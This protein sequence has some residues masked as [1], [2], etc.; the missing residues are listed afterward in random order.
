M[1]WL[2]G[3]RVGGGCGSLATV[4]MTAR[5]CSSWRCRSFAMSSSA[6]T[7]SS[8]RCLGGGRQV[9]GRMDP[10]IYRS[11]R[12]RAPNPGS[13]VRI[14]LPSGGHGRV[15]D[16]R[17][18]D[19][20]S[21]SPG[22]RDGR[23]GGRSDPPILRSGSWGAP[24]PGGGH[25]SLL[26]ADGH[27]REGQRCLGYRRGRVGVGVDTVDTRWWYS[28]RRGRGVPF[29]RWRFSQTRRGST[30]VKRGAPLIRVER[31]ASSGLV[32]RPP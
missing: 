8:T 14:C 7:S 3:R 4:A 15:G 28:T 25:R 5:A 26:P 6:S 17:R 27:G 19:V 9:G 22:L 21:S 20:S 2:L 12:S 29:V 30:R 31:R 18:G 10:P 16:R 32:G 1:A 11:G 13:V 24:N 23:V